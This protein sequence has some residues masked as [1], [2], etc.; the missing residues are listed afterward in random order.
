MSKVFFPASFYVVRP[1]LALMLIIP[2]E[3]YAPLL[4]FSTA[5]EV[6]EAIIVC[7]KRSSGTGGGGGGLRSAHCRRC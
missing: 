3:A 1:C 5:F 7:T 6:K 2:P 4:C